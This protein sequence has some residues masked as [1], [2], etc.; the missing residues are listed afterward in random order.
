MASNYLRA[1]K[2]EEKRLGEAGPTRPPSPLP[3]PACPATVKDYR[4]EKEVPHD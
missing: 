3:S 4:K 2:R 1:R